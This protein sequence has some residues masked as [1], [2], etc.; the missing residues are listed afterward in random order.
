MEVIVAVV[1]L[2]ILSTAFYGGLS[3]GFASMQSTREDLRA[4]QLLMQ[5]MEGL[6]L[7]N[8]NQLS[9]FSVNQPYD[10]LSTATGT[11][12]T[13][14]VAPEAAVAVPDTA[15][16]KPN[17]VQ[18]TV[19][20]SWTNTSYGRRIVEQRQMQTEVARYGLENYIWGVQ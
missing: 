9:S 15:S 7:C 14:S 18:V 19:T 11:I 17:M 10:P 5:S 13:V 8:W 1:V 3:A 16:Y 4:T 20:V 2:A 6:R 12:F